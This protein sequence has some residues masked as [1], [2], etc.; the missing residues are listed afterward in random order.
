MCLQITLPVRLKADVR[1]KIVK[2]YDSA[3]DD[4][5]KAEL[6]YINKK[7]F[8]VV[9]GLKRQDDR[10]LTQLAIVAN[11]MVKL[12]K[13]CQKNRAFLKLQSRREV[14]AALYYLCNPFDIIPDYIP[15]EGYADDMLVVNICLE[16]LSKRDPKAYDVLASKVATIKTP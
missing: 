16:R 3:I 6:E 14:I 2:A 12:L 4:V 11:K 5:G 15:G 1:K 8:K 13:T 9:K 7:Y 10:G